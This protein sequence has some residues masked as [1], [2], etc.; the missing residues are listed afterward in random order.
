MS[1]LARR[2]RDEPAR[3]VRRRATSV[4]RSTRPAFRQE[5]SHLYPFGPAADAGVPARPFRFGEPEAPLRRFSF[6]VTLISHQ[7]DI[8]VNGP[9][10]CRQR[11]SP[12]CRAPVDHARYS[13]A[14]SAARSQPVPDRCTGGH[15]IGSD[16]SIGRHRILQSA[17]T[18]PFN[19]P[20]YRVT[21]S[22]VPDV[23]L[24]PR[25]AARRRSP[26]RRPS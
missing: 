9:V 13:A 1:A 7:C 4:T 11:D 14:R 8:T 21:I 2:H 20:N 25:R 26:T 3:Q 23:A 15:V 18:I 10:G 17:D 16:P 6:T 12:D 22:H 19:Q 24:Y 5:S